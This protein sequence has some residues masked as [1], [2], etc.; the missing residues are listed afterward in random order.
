MEVCEILGLIF[1]LDFE[2]PSLHKEIRTFL[3]YKVVLV[4]FCNSHVGQ[5][6]H[7]GS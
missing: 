5:R 4:I 3:I 2:I 6:N 1:L 7:D